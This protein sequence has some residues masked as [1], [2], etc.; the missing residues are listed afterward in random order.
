MEKVVLWIKMPT[1]MFSPCNY[2]NC[3]RC[4]PPPLL[5]HWYW[6]CF[7]FFIWFE[8]NSAVLQEKKGNVVYLCCMQAFFLSPHQWMLN[9]GCNATMPC[10]CLHSP[11]LMTSK[12]FIAS[13]SLFEICLHGNIVNNYFLNILLFV[14]L[15]LLLPFFFFCFLMEWV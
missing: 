13:C 15:C 1:I 5:F 7:I 12:H 4:P 3:N 14:T 8:V 11:P 9:H 2:V 6:D 10:P